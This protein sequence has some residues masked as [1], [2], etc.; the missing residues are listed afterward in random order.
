[1]PGTW[2]VPGGRGEI[3]MVQRV[4]CRCRGGGGVAA[5]GAAIVYD[6]GRVRA[7]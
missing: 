1:M 5:G 4:L 2:V 3:T 6:N 7:P